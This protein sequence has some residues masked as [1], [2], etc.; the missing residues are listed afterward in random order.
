MDCKIVL[1][2]GGEPGQGCRTG[3][4][5]WSQGVGLGSSD[6][7]LSFWDLINVRSKFP[8]LGRQGPMCSGCLRGLRV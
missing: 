7:R 5:F 8:G 1:E 2:L 4:R 6:F 3:L